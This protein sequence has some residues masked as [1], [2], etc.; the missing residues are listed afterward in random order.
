MSKT[1]IWI[2]I[3]GFLLILNAIILGF[4]LIKNSPSLETIR[5]TP[6]YNC[7]TDIAKKFCENRNMEFIKVYSPTYRAIWYKEDF[8]CDDRG[9]RIDYTF[10]KKEE[11]KCKK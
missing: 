7:L 4:I 8:A 3:V 6:E 5:K 1:L 2:Y 11:I 10:T 9:N